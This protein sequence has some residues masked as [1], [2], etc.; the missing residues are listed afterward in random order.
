MRKAPRQGV[1]WRDHGGPV[2]HRERAA[3]QEVV[4]HVDDDEDVVASQGRAHRRDLYGRITVAPVVLRPSSARCT[5][6]ASRSGA[7]LWIWISTTPF[8]TAS[9]SEPE[10]S[11][12]TERWAVCVLRVGRVA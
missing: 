12:S 11:S 5:S 3:G 1:D 7:R 8:F 10:I 6:A 4:L 9:K 2:R